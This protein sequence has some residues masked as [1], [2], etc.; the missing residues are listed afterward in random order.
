MA[1]DDIAKLIY[2]ETERRLDVMQKDDYEFPVKA[3]KKDFIAIGALITVCVV[4]I[5]LCMIGV[6]K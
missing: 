1:K 2:D 3:D 4:L 5:G 6:I